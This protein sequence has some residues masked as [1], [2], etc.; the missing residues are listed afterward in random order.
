MGMSEVRRT[1]KEKGRSHHSEEN[2]KEIDLSYP[3]LQLC[4]SRLDIAAA[5]S[6]VV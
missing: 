4:Y 6:Y 3:H 1:E 5:T 2:E